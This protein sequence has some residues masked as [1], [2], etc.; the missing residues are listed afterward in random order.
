MTDPD[1]G[2]DRLPGYRKPPAEHRFRK[3]VSGNPKGR[4]R[5][6]RALVSTMIGGEPGIGLEDP[7]KSLAIEEAYRTITIREGGRTE[8]MPVIRAIMRKLAFAAA[9]GNIRA[10]QMYLNYLTSAEADRRMADME[11]LKTSVEYKEKWG[12]ILAERARN[13]TTGPEPLPHP[14][15]VIIDYETGTVRIEGPVLEEQKAARDTLR[16]QEP[17]LIKNW[18]KIEEQLKANPGDAALRKRGKDLR[19]ILDWLEAQHMKERVRE[20]MRPPSKKS[21]KG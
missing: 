15:D 10:Q 13:G 5:K 1:G 6:K 14:D 16:A 20:A 12:P 18:L 7:L 17:D 19:K 21:Q 4:P 8:K 9:N 11:M 3:G 2:E